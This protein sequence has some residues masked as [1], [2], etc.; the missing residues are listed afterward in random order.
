VSKTGTTTQ[1]EHILR[2]QAIE[3]IIQC[4]DKGD[5]VMWRAADLILEL[6]G[7]ASKGDGRPGGKLYLIGVEVQ[8]SIS[9]CAQLRATAQV[10]PPAAR[11]FRVPWSA[12][13][14]ALNEGENRHEV[15]RRTEALV[16]GGERTYSAKL[17]RDVS[18]QVLAEQGRAPR[19]YTKSTTVKATR[20]L[21]RLQAAL[22]AGAEVP[23]EEEARELRAAARAIDKTLTSRIRRSH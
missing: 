11:T 3:E 10:W 16:T 21:R 7:P 13:K 4:L 6:A 2:Q 14:D 9:F 8:R 5:E 15:L 23:S 1:Q 17:V 12:Y 18:V 20:Y 19:R 22:E